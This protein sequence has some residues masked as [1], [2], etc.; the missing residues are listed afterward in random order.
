MLKAVI[1]DMDGLMVDTEVISF[2]CYKDIIESYHFPFTLDE[3]IQSYPGRPLHTSIQFIKEHYQLD[4]QVEEK[5]QLFKS[6]E[7]KYMKKDGVQLKKGLLPLL[8]YLQDHHIQTIVAT[9]SIRERADQILNSHNI[10]KYFDDIVCGNEVKNGKPFPD[11]F[12]KAC[13]KLDVQTC[14]AL[15]LEDSEAGIQAAYDAQ[16]P[17]ICIPDMKY[18]HEKC[19]QKV[20]HI[21]TSLEDV[22]SYLE[23]HI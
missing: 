3:Y 5:I 13:E 4:F 11:I 20:E 17:V 14:N 9:S 8:Q 19:I 22:I 21:Y 2:Q 12:L 18:P 23:N 15:V 10:M 7:E 1:F 6:L 16:I